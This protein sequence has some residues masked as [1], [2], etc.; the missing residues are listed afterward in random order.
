M[1][2]YAKLDD[3]NTVID[4]LVVDDNSPDKTFN[5]VKDLQAQNGKIHLITEHEGFYFY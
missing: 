5:I 2:H 4:V 1:A 3:T